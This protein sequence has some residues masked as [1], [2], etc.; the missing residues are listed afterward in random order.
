[1]KIAKLGVVHD[2]SGKA[3]IVG[4]TNYW[5]QVIL[6]PLH[7]AIL[8][9]LEGIPM[10]G[11]FDQIAPINRLMSVVEPGQKFYSFDLSAATDRL[12][13]EIQADILNLLI[14]NIGTLW[15]NLLGSL[16]WEWKSTN[17][18]VPV[19]EISYSVGQPMG[20]YSSWA[21]LALSHHVIV[22][23]AAVNCGI[24]SFTHY[25]ILGDDI[26]IAN[27]AVAA[28][29]LVL[30]KALGVDINL[31]KS[32][33]SSSFCEFA[34]R[35]IGPN[36]LDLSP[37]GPGLILRTIRS[38]LYLAGLLD[39]MFRLK[40]IP[41][42]QATLASIQSLPSKYRGQRWNALWAAFGLNSFVLKGSQ[43]GNHNFMQ[44]LAWCFSISERTQSSAPFLMKSA[45]I[46]TI[47]EDKA[48]AQ[49]NLDDA[50]KYFS[51]N[52][53]STMVARDWPNRMLEFLL[54]LFSPGWWAYVSNFADKQLHLDSISVGAYSQN[55]TVEGLIDLISHDPFSI[56]VQNIDWK[57]RDAVQKSIE[58][59]QAIL[60][61][62]DQQLDDLLFIDSGSGFDIY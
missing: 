13:V 35:W 9:R 54:K 22:Q 23:C 20:A 6:K 16:K 41:N 12:P 49:S 59:G 47:I 26:V 53:W 19:K 43:T 45:L 25:A 29:Y 37:I 56:N 30:M 58:R 27:D 38:R 32:L 48:K 40:L 51:H 17:S 62:W 5:I 1:L 39:S 33:S 46:Q 7:D 2:Q 31:A 34:K 44:L 60:K 28:E 11:T 52:W 24:K 4:V 10:D 3:R 50:I 42:L 18:H 55:Y 61:A 36:G 8:S 21:M 57:D 15:M 14:P